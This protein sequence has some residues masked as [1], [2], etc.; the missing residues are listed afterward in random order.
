MVE[1]IDHPVDPGTQVEPQPGDT[2][3]PQTS[4]PA[5]INH[6][7][8]ATA[9]E[10]LKRDFHAFREQTTKERVEAEAYWVRIAELEKE[11]FLLR[12]TLEHRTVYNDS[13][14]RA[15]RIAGTPDSLQGQTGSMLP[16]GPSQIVYMSHPLTHPSFPLPG[17]Q[18]SSILNDSPLP[19]QPNP[20]AQ[21]IST[22]TTANSPNPPLDMPTRLLLQLSQTVTQLASRVACHAFQETLSDKA[23]SW[24]LSLPPNS[25]DNFDQLSERFLNRFIL[26]TSIYRTVDALFHIKQKEGEGLHELL[27]RWQSAT[28]RCH[29]LE[30]RVAE[31]AFRQALLPG[32]FLME[33]NKNPP[34]SYD[35]LMDLAVRWARAEFATFRRPAHATLALTA[36]ALD[37]HFGRGQEKG[38]SHG[39]SREQGCGSDR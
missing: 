13:L 35:A 36:P 2:S 29:N 33:I 1:I 27:S 30:P 8:P 25:I 21:P 7:D 17:P 19:H 20:S 39:P 31:Q 23:L 4:S 15:T 24:F 22:S 12:A 3:L 28:A 32:S 5:P 18:P 10:I 26:H 37:E 14:D 16:G 9:L 6:P 38:Q 11:Q 34:G